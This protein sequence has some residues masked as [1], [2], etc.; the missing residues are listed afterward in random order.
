MV[1][2]PSVGHFNIFF[3]KVLAF[4]EGHFFK[5]RCGWCKRELCEV[6]NGSAKSALKIN[7]LRVYFSSS[8]F[9]LRMLRPIS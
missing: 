4:F 6:L 3:K 5:E 7:Y 8:K 2:G 1:I 9:D